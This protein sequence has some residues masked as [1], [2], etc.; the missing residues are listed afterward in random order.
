MNWN[1]GFIMFK[2]EALASRG[3]F[4]APKMYA[5]LVHDNEGVKYDTPDLKTLGIALVRSSTPNCVK[6]PLRDCV[7][8]ILTGNE[9]TLQSFVKA[10][11]TLYYELSPETISFPRSANNLAKYSSKTEIYQKKT[12]I[13]VRA[14]LLYN[15]RVSA[16]KL[17]N[18]DPI[19]EGDKIRYIYLKEPNTLRENVIGFVGKFPPEFNL[20]RYVD[21]ATMWDKSFIAPLKKLT[22]AVGWNW[23]ETNTL[24]SLFE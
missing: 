21:Y 6:E 22:D 7:M 17:K 23:E 8:Q 13:A 9:K 4:L 10:Q 20:I 5:L 11:E 12:P 1:P 18:Y 16:L 15:D 14:A 2:R 24:D 3:L 19:R